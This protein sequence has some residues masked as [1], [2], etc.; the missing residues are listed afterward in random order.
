MKILAVDGREI[1]VAFAD[2]FEDGFLKDVIS[3]HYHEIP[4]A[5][6]IAKRLLPLYMKTL[7]GRWKAK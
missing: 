4:A 6:A 2:Y 7:F 3:I 1:C 5:S